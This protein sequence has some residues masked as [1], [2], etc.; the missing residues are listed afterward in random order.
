MHSELSER[1]ELVHEMPS[2]AGF[3]MAV[4]A[5]VAFVRSSRPSVVVRRHFVTRS[6]KPGA[7]RQDGYACG[8][9]RNQNR[10][11]NQ[12]RRMSCKRPEPRQSLHSVDRPALSPGDRT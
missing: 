12:Y 8:R 11:Q 1:D 7:V 9:N 6:A 5:P 10:R 3:H 2:R 4:D